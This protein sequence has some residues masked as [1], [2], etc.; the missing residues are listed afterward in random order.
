MGNASAKR[1]SAR[2]VGRGGL[3]AWTYDN[4]E[5][6]ELEKEIVFRRNWLL[7]G[8]ANEIPKP[9][10]FMTLDAADERALVVRGRDG[11]VRAFHN[12]CRHRGSRVVAEP[13]G[14]CGS[15]ITCPFHGWSYD[16]DGRLREQ[17]DRRPVR[18]RETNG[19]T[20]HRFGEL[21]VPFCT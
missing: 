2:N 4:D 12:L 6:M 5:L 15:V 17:Q 9:G 20:A 14:N 11:E 13:G 10:D 8:H 3:P 19:R 21:L 1:V 7:V 18:P 16:L